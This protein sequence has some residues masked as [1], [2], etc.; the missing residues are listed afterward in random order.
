MRPLTI[1]LDGDEFHV[2]INEY[3]FASNAPNSI[4]FG[5]NL[6]IHEEMCLIGKQHSYVPGKLW[7]FARIYF[8]LCFTYLPLGLVIWVSKATE[9]MLCKIG[10]K[11]ECYNCKGSPKII[12]GANIKSSSLKGSQSSYNYYGKSFIPLESHPV[13]QLM[14][15]IDLKVYFQSST[16]P[17]IPSHMY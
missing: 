4:G 8:T 7:K 2:R 15:S 17:T 12:F 16:L 5:L 9:E 13:I 14:M 3:Y 10:C 1:F 6:M 11:T